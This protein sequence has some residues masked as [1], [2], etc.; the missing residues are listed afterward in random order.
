MTIDPIELARQYPE[1]WNNEILGETTSIYF[2]VHEITK[3]KENQRI[4]WICDGGKPP[5]SGC[6]SGITDFHQTDKMG[7]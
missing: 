7:V 6:F 4:G 1:R 2:H 5:F 3:I